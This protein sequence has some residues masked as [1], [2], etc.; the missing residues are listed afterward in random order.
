MGANGIY[1][2]LVLQCTCIRPVHLLCNLLCTTAYK[3]LYK[4]IVLKKKS[5]LFNLSKLSVTL[6]KLGEGENKG[7]TVFNIPSDE[8]ECYVKFEIFYRLIFIAQV[9]SIILFW[10]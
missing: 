6:S 9:L 3:I 5:I 7:G 4:T 2:K 10:H 1:V 8:Y